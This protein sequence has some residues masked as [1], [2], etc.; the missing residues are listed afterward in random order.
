MKRLKFVKHLKDSDCV[1][2]REGSNHTVFMNKKT[3]IKTSVPRHADI[4]ERI[5]FE[6]C[7]QLGIPQPKIN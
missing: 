4:S 5:A 1:I 6:I 3:R 2:F 7:K